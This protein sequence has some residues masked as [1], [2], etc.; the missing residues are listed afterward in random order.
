M[1]QSLK[2]A[3]CSAPTRFKNPADNWLYFSLF[4][5]RG[6]LKTMIQGPVALSQIQIGCQCPGHIILGFFYRQFHLVPGGKITGN[7]RGKSTTG[8]MGIG[9]IDFTPGNQTSS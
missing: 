7:G 9:I 8:T 4:A 6:Q 3:N 2:K 5:S 1:A